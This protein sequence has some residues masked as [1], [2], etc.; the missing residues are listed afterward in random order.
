MNIKV[1]Y[2]YAQDDMKFTS[3]CYDAQ[4]FVDGKEVPLPFEEDYPYS[5]T[6]AFV[7]GMMVINPKA[8]LEETQVADLDI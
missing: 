5:H 4:V 8:T 2:H 1:I 7:A 6:Q 3:D